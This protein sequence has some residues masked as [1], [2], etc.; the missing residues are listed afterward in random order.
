MQV[1]GDKG[2]EVER[3]RAWRSPNESS[4]LDQSTCTTILVADQEGYRYTRFLADQSQPPYP[5]VGL[6]LVVAPGPGSP[7]RILVAAQQAPACERARSL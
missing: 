4:T 3:A 1:E 2:R 7:V 5:P 6:F